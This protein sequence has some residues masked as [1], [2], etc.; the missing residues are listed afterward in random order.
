M[1]LDGC[2][3]VDDGLHGNTVFE[4]ST[5]DDQVMLCDA[6]PVVM[7]TYRYY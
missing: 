3:T 6:L 1:P 2:V 7:V 5:L 4:C